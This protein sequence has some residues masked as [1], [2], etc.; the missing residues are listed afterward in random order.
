MVHLYRCTF[1][2]FFPTVHY[3]LSQKDKIK[4]IESLSYVNL[5]DYILTIYK[6]EVHL[7]YHFNSVWSRASR[8]WSSGSPTQSIKKIP[9][10]QV[11][12]K[13]DN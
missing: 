3:N 7:S 5:E 11:Y 10:I 4:S 2:Y 8:T 12:N 1:F 6:K 9:F 13:T